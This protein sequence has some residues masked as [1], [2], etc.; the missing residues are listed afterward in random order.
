MILKPILGVLL[1]IIAGTFLGRWLSVIEEYA[2]VEIMSSQEPELGLPVYAQFIVTQRLRIEEPVE[3]VSLFVPMHVPDT[4]LPFTVRLLQGDRVVREWQSVSGDYSLIGLTS[5]S[6]EIEIEFDGSEITHE[7]KDTA[8]RLYAESL[9]SAYPI[10]NYRI[11][12][13]EKEGDVGLTITA[14]RL[15]IDRFL[16]EWRDQPLRGSVQIGAVLLLFLLLGV[17]PWVMVK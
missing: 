15:R 10:G 2:V 7:Q 9:D 6:G 17:L 8:P 12:E 11:A 5:L 16:S 13:N 4:S 14:R 1:V 3:A